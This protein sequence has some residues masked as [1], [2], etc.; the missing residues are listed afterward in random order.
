MSTKFPKKTNYLVIDGN[1]TKYTYNQW[2]KL[3]VKILKDGR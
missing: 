1:L 2:L 3:L